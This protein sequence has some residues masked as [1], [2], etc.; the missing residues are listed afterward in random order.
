MNMN[1]NMSLNNNNGNANIVNS[2]GLYGNNN[3]SFN[4][5]IDRFLY[6]L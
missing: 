2:V 4:G 3:Y 6:P 1:V 5:T